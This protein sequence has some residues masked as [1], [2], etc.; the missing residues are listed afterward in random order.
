MRV[1]VAFDV[2]NYVEVMEG[3]PL[4]QE[5][6]TFSLEREGNVLKRVCLSF[7]GVSIAHAPTFRQ[8]SDTS[9]SM[10]LKISDGDYVNI[11]RK[12]IMNWQ[13]VVSGIQIVNL[14]YD[15]PEI[16]YHAESNE[17]EPRIGVKSFK[18]SYD[19]ALNSSCDFEQIGRAFC[20]RQ[21]PDDR[22]ESTS[23]YREGRL[24][25]E[26]GRYVDAYNNF[27]LFL[28]TRYCDGK[29]KTTQQVEL[30]TDEQVL[31]SSIENATKNMALSNQTQSYEKFDLFEADAS[32]KD[33]I[34]SLVLLRGKL[35]HHSLKSP[36]R[37]DPNQQ[38]KYKGEA[39]FLMAVVHHIVIE[40]SLA[41]IYAPEPIEQFREQSVNSGN[42]VKIRLKTHR[43]K[44]GR[45]LVLE[46]SYPTT[47]VS[48]RLC[49]TAVRHAIQACARDAQLADTAGF[50]AVHIKRDLEIFTIDFDVWAY[51]ATREIEPLKPIEFIR[52]SFEQ[53]RTDLI[54]RHEFSIPCRSSKLSILDVWKL[55]SCSFDHIEKRDPTARIMNLKLFVN[56][57]AKAIVVY[58]VG[59]LV[60]D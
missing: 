16:R 55:L 2:K 21:I 58:R 52:C 53:F 44:K 20:A 29:T 26:V 7:S 36:H 22:I 13:A 38:D 46:M 8:S 37:W 47:V 51:T 42:E 33:K 9:V 24:A 43:V 6:M 27:F 56:D 14:D 35:R 4:M 5:N 48:S 1:T 28:E 30:L 15:S 31:R 50:E 59:A 60:K 32:H 25:F 34:K 49:L 18:S 19:H 39:Q 54:T 41:E 23:H 57:G 40:E 17:E 11:A 10:E 3:W 45:A 12:R